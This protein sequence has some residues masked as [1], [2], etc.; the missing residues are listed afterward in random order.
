MKLVP[1]ELLLVGLG[2][3][4]GAVSRFAVGLLFERDATRLPVATLIVNLLGCLV[5]GWLYG[6]GWLN[7]SER[8]RL[9][10]AVG[11]L[12]AFTTF[13]AFALETIQLWENGQAWWAAINVGMSLVG[14]L[15]IVVLGVLIGKQFS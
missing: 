13:S 8:I 14:G 7:S 4:L 12:G 2:G 15:A 9:L 5:I 3:V 1:F 11:F 6:S 10:V